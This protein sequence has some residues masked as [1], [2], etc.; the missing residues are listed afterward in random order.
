MSPRRTL[1]LMVS[2]SL[3]LA[4]WLAAYT[5]LGN[6]SEFGVPQAPVPGVARENPAVSSRQEREAKILAPLQH[7]AATRNKDTEARLTESFLTRRKPVYLRYLKSWSSTPQTCD[8]VFAILLEREQA[9]WEARHQRNIG[10]MEALRQP[11]GI[12]EKNTA[13]WKLVDLLGGRKRESNQDC[14]R[15]YVC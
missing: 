4:V 7:A 11:V 8:A 2:L 12:A 1:I 15:A 9:I 10:G 3:G 6:S 14:G 13:H 5:D